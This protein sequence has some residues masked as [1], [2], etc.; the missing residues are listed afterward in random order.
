MKEDVGG[1][2]VETTTKKN[3]NTWVQLFIIIKEALWG[4]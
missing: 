3:H 1:E 4:T 2:G